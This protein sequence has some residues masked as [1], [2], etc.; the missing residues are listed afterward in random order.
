MSEINPPNPEQNLFSLNAQI[1]YISN[2]L[3]KDNP[4]LNKIKDVFQNRNELNAIKSGISTELEHLSEKAAEEIKDDLEGLRVNWEKI[5]GNLQEEQEITA[6]LQTAAGEL[7]KQMTQIYEKNFHAEQVSSWEGYSGKITQ[8]V[9]PYFEQTS[10]AGQIEEKYPL[11]IKHLFDLAVKLNNGD[12]GHKTKEALH[13]SLETPSMHNAVFSLLLFDICHQHGEN[14]KKNLPEVFYKLKNS[15]NYEEL[16]QTLQKMETREIE[17]ILLANNEDLTPQQLWCR[18]ELQRMVAGTKVKTSDLNALRQIFEHNLNKL[19]N[20]SH[21]TIRLFMGMGQIE[22]AI[23]AAKALKNPHEQSKSYADLVATLLQNNKYDKATEL[24]STILNQTERNKADLKIVDKYVQENK[25]EEAIAF[26]TS[27]EPEE[28]KGALQEIAMKFVD[29]G[30]IE[31][32]VEI[33]KII[34][35]FDDRNYAQSRLVNKIASKGYFAPAIKV[36]LDI[37]DPE[38]REDALS[39]IIKKMLSVRQIEEALRL[40][41]QIPNQR[42]KTKATKIVESAMVAFQQDEKV[43]S[44]RNLI[45]S[46]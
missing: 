6:L 19:E 33:T 28:R 15:S 29:D 24:A 34:E 45:S 26:A 39:Y 17:P 21:L 9:Q 37:E 36:A 8:A 18:K 2:R 16:F 43:K 42:E 20:P 44:I 3:K 41:Q 10:D 46:R 5:K 14:F 22:K 1:N 31:K 12:Y 13:A 27:L 35:D 30:K 23:A 38:F 7:K 25:M 32:A 4:A 11:T 40:I